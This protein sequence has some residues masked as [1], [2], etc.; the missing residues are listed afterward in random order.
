MTPAQRIE[1]ALAESKPSGM[2]DVVHKGDDVF[3]E[4]A[5]RGVTAQLCVDTVCW[6]RVS[7]GTDVRQSEEGGRTLL[8]TFATKLAVETRV[9][10]P[11]NADT[12]MGTCAHAMRKASCHFMMLKKGV[13][14]TGFQYLWKCHAYGSPAL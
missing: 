11:L 3:G 13:S 14:I 8:V 5:V 6:V 10:E 12:A 1:A 7:K 2:K 4:G 9:R